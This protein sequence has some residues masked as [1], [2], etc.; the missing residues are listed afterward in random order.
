MRCDIGGDVRHFPFLDNRILSLPPELSRKDSL[1]DE[2][3]FWP[4]GINDRCDVNIGICS[5]LKLRL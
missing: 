1:E 2:G 3:Y 5:G 4:D